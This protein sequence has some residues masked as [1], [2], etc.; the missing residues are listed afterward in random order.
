M[1]DALI[2]P[3]NE[4][5]SIVVSTDNSGG[6]GIKPDDV[7][8]VTYDVVAYYS[9]R[10]AIMDCMAAGGD[11]FSVLIHNF[12]QENSWVE[13]NA[14]INKGIS[15][16]GLTSIQVIGSTESNFSLLQSALGITVLGKKR[17]KER[18][19]QQLFIKFA[20]IGTPLVGN[21]V[22]E[23]A[24][25]VAPL[26][27]FKWMCQQKDVIHILPVGSKGILYKLKQIYPEFGQVQAKSDLDLFKSGGPGTCF[28]IAFHEESEDLIIEKAGPYFHRLRE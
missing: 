2:I 14:G 4:T 11:P 17:N 19:E 3:F 15:E 7:V 13:I 1:S 27:L 5:E 22:I 18:N 24:D 10:V 6:I 20:V 21:E 12:C 16:M 23:H 8:K 26:S 9:F 25:Q 28:L